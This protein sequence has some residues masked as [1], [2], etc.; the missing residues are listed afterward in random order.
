MFK[1]TRTRTRILIYK[2]TF[3]LVINKMSSFLFLYF[4]TYQSIVGE[5][6]I[7]NLEH[8]RDKNLTPMFVVA[9][10][11]SLKLYYKIGVLTNIKTSI[12]V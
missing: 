3:L 4:L 5:I 6:V 11:T 1:L 12:D 8:A 9:R 7:K 2:K 10:L